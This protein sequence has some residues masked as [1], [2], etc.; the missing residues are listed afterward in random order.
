MPDYKTTRTTQSIVTQEVTAPT[1][2][3]QIFVRTLIG[4]TILIQT[5]QPINVA[6]LKSRIYDKEGIPEYLQR[7]TQKGELLTND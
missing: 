5:E 3:M 4:R 1:I 7:L 2:K 6:A